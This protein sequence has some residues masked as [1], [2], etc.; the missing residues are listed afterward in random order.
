MKRE[1][2]PRVT[3]RWYRSPEIILKQK[4]YGK[5]ADVWS[6]GCIF[7]ELLQLMNGD[8]RGPLF[9][10]SECRPL[11]PRPND[12]DDFPNDMEPS[13]RDQLYKIIFAV[14]TPDKIQRSFISSEK[15][16]AYVCKFPYSNG[17]WFREYILQ[18]FSIEAKDLLL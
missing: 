3:S 9:N 17:S 5:P 11:S 14:R 12:D 4:D 2:S 6:M 13:V 16:E 18:P 8:K 1:L 10:G 7:I 15:A